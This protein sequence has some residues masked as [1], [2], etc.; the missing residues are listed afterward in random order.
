M[1]S[2]AKLEFKFNNSTDAL[3]ASLQ[4]MLAYITDIIP[5]EADN[6]DILFRC[7]VIITE[8][9]TNAIKHAGENIT[10]FDIE[11]DT[12]QLIIRKTDH[13]SPLYLVDMHDH[14][15]ADKPA[16]KKLISA[17]PLNSL[18]A[19]WE[20]ESSIR[21]VSEEGSMD[22]FLAVEEVMEHFG[23]LIISRSAD[24]FTYTYDKEIGSNTFRVRIDF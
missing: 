24:E 17:D 12:R 23:I 10:S 4:H 16:N 11:T 14:S 1:Q 8:L 7:K 15:P 21:F 19:C 6:D 22:D 2:C 13:G 18:Y 9:L 3:I 5:A 20:S